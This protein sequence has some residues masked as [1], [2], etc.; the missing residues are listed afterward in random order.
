MVCY[1]FIVGILTDTRFPTASSARQRLVVVWVRGNCRS[2]SQ[3]NLTY[4]VL[5]VEIDSTVT[6]LVV[7]VSRLQCDAYLLP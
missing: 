1:Q 4:L 3:R 5:S 7:A 2:L 6:A